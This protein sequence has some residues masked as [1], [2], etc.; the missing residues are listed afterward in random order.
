[1]ARLIILWL[2]V[3][4]F[5]FPNFIS[6][7]ACGS[8]ADISGLIANGTTPIINGGT[9]YMDA[10]PSSV[11]FSWSSP[12]VLSPTSSDSCSIV[13]GCSTLNKNGLYVNGSQIVGSNYIWEVARGNPAVASGYAVRLS[14]IG[15]IPFPRQECTFVIG[16]CPPGSYNLKETNCYNELDD[17]I[18]F[19]NS[20]NSH[21]E[22]RTS[23]SGAWIN[24]GYLTQ[25]T[26]LI[27]PGNIYFGVRTVYGSTACEEKNFNFTAVYI[28]K[29][30]L[31]VSK[32]GLGSVTSAPVGI[33]CGGDCSELYNQGTTVTLTALPSTGYTFIGW[34]VLGGGSCS[35]TGDCVVTMNSAKDVNANFVINSYV[36]TTNKIGTGLGTITGAGTYTHGTIVNATALANTGS[37]FSNWG[38]CDLVVGT[39]CNITMN[40]AKNITATFTLNTYLLNIIK[41]GLGSVTSSL[42]GINCGPSCTKD[43]NFGDVV[44]LTAIS[45]TGYLFTGWSGGSCSGMGDCVV[46]MNSAKSITA[47]FTQLACALPVPVGEGIIINSG[48]PTQI[49]QSWIYSNISPS[50]SCSWNCTSGYYRGNSPGLDENKCKPLFNG[51]PIPEDCNIKFFEIQTTTSVK[52]MTIEYS[53]YFD[54]VDVNLLIFD[55]EG[56]KV[57]PLNSDSIQLTDLNSCDIN[58]NIFLISNWPTEGVKSN[59]YMGQLFTS[60]KCVKQAFF[61]VDNKSSKQATIPDSNML[62]AILVCMSVVSLILF[63]KRKV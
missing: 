59:A 50:P 60:S 27:S 6:A 12:L 21:Y 56:N 4:L 7:L 19:C 10:V 1:M 25:K 9:Y 28:P 14:P 41:V 62:I 16:Q 33:N 39:D 37:T 22:Y 63:S 55:L 35:G 11:T 44:T 13:S 26:L 46:T 42:G 5:V 43:F 15:A 8:S 57:Y 17:N 36:L 2:L 52:G 53:C 18:S 54:S 32:V 3:A 48:V 58:K 49:N 61:V 23:S 51:T 38:G 34:S 30:N 45:S 40:S 47:T 29:Y 31:S 20:S 24:L